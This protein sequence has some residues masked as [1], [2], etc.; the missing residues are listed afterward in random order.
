M[1]EP[2]RPPTP[3]ADTVRLACLPELIDDETLALALRMS[4]RAARRELRQGRFGPYSRIGRRLFVRRESLLDA[5]ASQ[6]RQP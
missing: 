6:E 5:I 3:H 4:R 2:E 1:D